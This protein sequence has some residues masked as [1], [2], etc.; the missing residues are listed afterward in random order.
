MKKSLM[1]VVVAHA[2]FAMATLPS[3]VKAQNDDAKSS[4]TGGE[5]RGTLQHK[6]PAT[7]EKTHPKLQGRAG[8]AQHN[9]V[10]AE[11]QTSAPSLKPSEPATLAAPGNEVTNFQGWTV[12]CLPNPTDNS[13]RTCVAKMGVIK[14]NEDKRPILFF[15]VIK[16][17]PKVVL[18]LQ[19]PTGIDLRAGTVLQF[20]KAPPRTLYYESCEPALCTATVQIDDGL[21]QELAGAS[22]A[23]ST[24]MGLGVGEV[25]VEYPLQEVRNALT[26]LLSK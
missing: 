6:L 22:A 4:A 5:K 12:T 18:A 10:A 16:T 11:S 2:I 19:T 17:G 1:K 21:L 9:A 23:T 8:P 13:P 25:R 26:L 15:N 3:G 14:S 7:L 20:G 24:W